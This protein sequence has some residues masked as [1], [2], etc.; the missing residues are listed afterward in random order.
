[1]AY[2]NWNLASIV[3]YQMDDVTSGTDTLAWYF[4]ISGQCPA[5]MSLM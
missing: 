4:T 2:K 3:P 5:T 1:M